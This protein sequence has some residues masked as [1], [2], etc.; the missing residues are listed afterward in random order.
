MHKQETQLNVHIE[1]YKQ[2]EIWSE[3]ENQHCCGGSIDFTISPL[4][5][6]HHTLNCIDYH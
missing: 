5:I 1:A 6:V 3:E 4:H 2:C